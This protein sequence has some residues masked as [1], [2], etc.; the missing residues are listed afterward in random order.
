MRKKDEFATGTDDC[1]KS[2]IVIPGFVQSKGLL[3][4]RQLKWNAN[5]VF[6]ISDCAPA[7][8]SLAKFP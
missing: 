7:V 4:H 8:A 6:S 2:F 5:F 1:K 3:C